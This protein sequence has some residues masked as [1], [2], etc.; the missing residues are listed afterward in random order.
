ML[1]YLKPYND[2]ASVNFIC[3]TALKFME[4]KSCRIIC[5]NSKEYF[6]KTCLENNSKHKNGL[7]SVVHTPVHSYKVFIIANLYKFDA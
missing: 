5:K 4:E 3:E 2:Y 6:C 1:F 7:Y